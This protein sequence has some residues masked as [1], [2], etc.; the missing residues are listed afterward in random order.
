MGK[1]WN[2][3]RVLI[4]LLMIFMTVT[5]VYP[6]YFMFINALKTTNEYFMDQF[7]LPQRFDLTN[8]QVIIQDFNIFHYFKNTAIVAVASTAMIV[9]FGLF[10]AYAFAKLNF[11]GKNLVY[12]LILSTMFMP[13]Q[14]S[15]IP[16]YVM[17]S[18][19]KLI[20]TFSSVILTYLAMGLPNAILL[21]R[22]AFMGI[23]NE[24]LE[25]AKLDGAG[26]FSTV[27]RLILPMGMASL[28]IVVIFNFVGYWNDLLTPLLYLTQSSKQTVMVALSALVQRNSRLPTRQLAGLILSALPTVILY[29][30]LQ[31]Y[32]VKG[33]TV[34]SIK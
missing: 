31:K 30:C 29:L 20:N 1:K 34:G 23:S 13:A 14:V 3:T 25:S 4:T 22:G 18:K 17:F 33:M 21:M 6:L 32:M 24:M 11:K 9:F 15:M 7:A 2:A 8:F 26:Y 16:A 12:L 28:S 10:A 19:A 5:F 27:F